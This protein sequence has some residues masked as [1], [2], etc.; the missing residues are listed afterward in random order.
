MLKL[1]IKKQMSEIFRAYF[2]NVKTGKGR[3]KAATIGLIALYVLLLGGVLGGMFT[4]LSLSLCEPLHA[5]GMGWLYYLI[6]SMVA[7]LL[8]AFGS[9]FSTFSGLYLAKDN[10]LLLSM[11]V[12]VQAIIT[13]RLLSVYLMGLL[14]SGI[15]IVPAVIVY[16]IVAGHSAAEITGGLLLILLIS[17]IVLI[18]SCLLGYVVA[19]ISTKLKN[20]S[21]MTTLLALLFFG[22]YYFFYFR[23]Q[24]ILQD[25][26]Q[27]MLIYGQKIKGSAYGLYLF[28]LIGEGEWLPMLI[29]TAGIGLIGAGIWIL[30][31][32][33][34]IKIVTSTAAV[35]RTRYREKK[36]RMSDADGALL[37]KEFGRLTGSANYML[38]CSL[39][40]L[41]LIV[42]GA[43]LLI[44]GGDLLTTLKTVF[45]EGD[46]GGS[47]SVTVLFCAA[48]CM[49]AGMNDM[50]APA[51]SLEGK[52]LWIARSL[53]VSSWQILKAKLRL[54]MFLT[55]LPALFCAVCGAAVMKVSLPDA[56]LLVA[57][58]VLFTVKTAA[59]DLTLGLLRPNLNWTNE[60]YP[61]KQSVSI[62][63]AL[64]L[65]MV[66]AAVI[67]LFYLLIG[68]WL[69]GYRIFMALLLF[70][71]GLITLGLC[72]W[73]KK[74]G[75]KRLEEL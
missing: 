31:S 65:P 33:S 74:R 68:W 55:T 25:L 57:V 14:Y 60:I 7:V 50:A 8:G 39:S 63:I 15:V 43:A 16:W 58:P 62:L 1:L 47:G 9:V 27:N 54:Q 59:L 61:I 38:N 64:L 69:I 2:Y 20:K 23:A 28:G 26:M 10:D 56:L 21:Y 18:L 73:L 70:V 17:V 49:I 72:M 5:G 6:M 34:F 13:S 32:R 48:V 42:A 35:S 22:A 11:P 37:R 24:E 46:M 12:P 44:K 67:G 53:P 40:T 3:S 41:L 30:L 45:E 51:V 19:R 52:S 4:M 36:A 66:F 71:M 29:Y 75:T